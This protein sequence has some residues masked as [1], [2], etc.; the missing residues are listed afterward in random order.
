MSFGFDILRAEQR[1][2]IDS[3]GADGTTIWREGTAQFRGVELLAAAPAGFWGLVTGLAGS[4]LPAGAPVPATAEEWLYLAQNDVEIEARLIR[5]WAA[6]E[7]AGG[8]E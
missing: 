4:I 6:Y 7:A 8:L 2:Q 5:T 1:T 3:G